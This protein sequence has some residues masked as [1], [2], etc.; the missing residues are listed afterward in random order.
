MK[1]KFKRRDTA[2]SVGRYVP[3][4]GQH[5]TIYNII[6]HYNTL[7]RLKLSANSEGSQMSGYL[8]RKGRG[9]RWKLNWF[10][11]K[12]RVLYTYR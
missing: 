6:I 8:R 4:V 12:D 1:I 10:V 7:Q 2:R 11:L 3:Q 9:Q 5:I